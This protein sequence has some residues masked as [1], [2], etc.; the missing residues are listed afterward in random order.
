[1]KRKKKKQHGGR[2]GGGENCFTK[3]IYSMETLLIKLEQK[4]CYL[5]INRTQEYK[6]AEESESYER[7]A[8]QK[9]QT[10][11]VIKH[12]DKDILC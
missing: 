11:H 4:V 2:D 12:H 1:M 7:A 3:I 10:L 9:E 6:W 8:R 5:K